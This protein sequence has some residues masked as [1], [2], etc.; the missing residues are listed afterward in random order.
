MALFGFEVNEFSPRLV[1]MQNKFVHNAESVILLIVGVMH[2]FD[3]I[4]GSQCQVKT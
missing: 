2:C 1:N 3:P 4:V